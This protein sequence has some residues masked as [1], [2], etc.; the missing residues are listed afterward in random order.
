M[1]HPY[2]T[3]GEKQN[4]DTVDEDGL[5]TFV[6]NYPHVQVMIY[7]DDPSSSLNCVVGRTFHGDNLRD[8]D[9]VC[10][11]ENPRYHYK[12]GYTRLRETLRDAASQGF[13]NIDKLYIPW[14]R[15]VKVVVEKET[16]NVLQFKWKKVG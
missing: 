15:I 13:L 4:E 7:Y 9:Y 6:D 11:S 2:R 14:H 3:P 5:R 12:D 16:E 10:A 1:N 8:T